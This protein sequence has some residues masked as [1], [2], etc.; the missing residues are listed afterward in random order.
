[1]V[2]DDPTYKRVIEQVRDIIRMLEQE[3][4]KLAEIVRKTPQSY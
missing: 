2:R 1:M 3:K 4:E